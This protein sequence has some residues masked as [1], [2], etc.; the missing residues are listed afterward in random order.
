MAQSYL[1]TGDIA[2]GIIAKTLCRFR[3][4]ET[5]EYFTGYFCIILL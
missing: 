4:V 5:C 3:Q 2:K 1:C